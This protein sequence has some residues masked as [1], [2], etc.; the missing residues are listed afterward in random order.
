MARKWPFFGAKLFSAKVGFL[1]LSGAWET[2]L[3]I[4]RPVISSKFSGKWRHDGKKLVSSEKI[5]FIETLWIPC[6]TVLPSIGSPMESECAM[7]GIIMISMASI[8]KLKQ[9]SEARYAEVQHTL[10][11]SEK[12]L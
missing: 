7:L 11:L 9:N 2:K 4:T 6:Y 1:N 3:L 12:C 8:K 5:Q 10:L